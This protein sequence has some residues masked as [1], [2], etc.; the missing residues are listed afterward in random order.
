MF[1]AVGDVIRGN[2]AFK[3]FLESPDFEKA[4]EEKLID[5]DP[6][7]MKLLKSVKSSRPKY[8]EIFMDT[9][10]GVGVVR[11]VVDPFSYYVY[12]SDGREVAEIESMVSKG[13]PYEE[14]IKE[15]VRK[16]RS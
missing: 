12:T 6:F 9:P 11:L 7:T 2:S 15:M 13:M 3:F 1:G 4:K 8:S 16:Y 10:F 14:A 5:Y